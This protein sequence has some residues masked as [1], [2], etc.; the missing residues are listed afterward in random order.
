[1]TDRIPFRD[2]IARQPQ[3]LATALATTSSALDAID[4]EPLRAGTIGLVGIGASLY[5]AIAGASALRDHGRRTVAL[6][7]GELY[8]PAVDAADAYIA[9][10]AS[11]RSIEPAR[12]MELRPAAA[13]YGIAKAKDTPLGKFVRAMIG[14]GSGADSGPNTTSY[15]GSLQAIGLIGERVGKTSGYDWSELPGMVADVLASSRE[16]V[17][18]AARLLA[19][20]AAL[21]CVGSH[22]AYGTAGYASLLLREAVRVPAQSWDTLN[23]LHGPMEP[24]D[25]R[26]GVI[27]FG[28]GREVQLAQDLADFGIATVLVTHGAVAERPNLTAIVTPGVG[29]SLADAILQAVPTQW[30]VADLADAAGLPQCIFRYRQ[31]DTKLE[32]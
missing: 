13:T 20:K 15:L 31:K 10:S 19:G 18:R 12:A 21:D 7:G 3:A 11:G 16:A 24:N 1:M 9:I 8:D 22:A 30:L 25:V 2:A 6:S 26:T 23:F 4:L 17:G 29:N 14:T 27:V 5:A 28:D 32:V